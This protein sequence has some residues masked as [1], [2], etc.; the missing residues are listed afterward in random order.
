M[1][2]IKPALTAEEW[3]THFASSGDIAV[4][5]ANAAD[6]GQFHVVAALALYGQKFGFTREHARALREIADEQES[7]L[8]N[9]HWGMTDDR[10][11]ARYQIIQTREAAD[12]IEALLPPEKP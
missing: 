12:R 9:P 1:S 8:K 6:Q 11:R 10:S 7:R 5:I 3:E 4:E 2:D